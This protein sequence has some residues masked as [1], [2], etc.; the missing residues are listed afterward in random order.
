M[1]SR[2]KAATSTATELERQVYE[3]VLLDT[4]VHELNTVRGLLGEPTRL[5]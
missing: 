4:L 3:M 1:K 2:P 5:D